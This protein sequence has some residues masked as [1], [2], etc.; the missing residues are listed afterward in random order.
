MSFRKDMPHNQLQKFVIIDYSREMII[1]G[2]IKSDGKE[3]IAG[4][5][6]YSINRDTHTAEIAIVVRDDYQ[7]RGVASE[8]LSYLTYLAQAQ[9]LL[10][11]TAEVL[12]E[13]QPM[14]HL[15]EKAG[16]D[17]ERRIDGGIHELKI[18]FRTH[19][20]GHV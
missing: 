8:I 6:Q 11:F 15:F 12:M 2:I 3:E 18:L 1:L 19:V 16:F 17:I 7:N 10:G 5:G 4:L 9:G 14:L 13:N 20:S